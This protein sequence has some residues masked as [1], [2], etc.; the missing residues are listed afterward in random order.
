MSASLIALGVVCHRGRV[1]LIRRVHHDPPHLVWA[2]PG[3]KV[4]AGETPEA[5]I[6]REVN[7]ETNVPVTVQAHLHTR[8]I[9][10]TAVTAHYFVCAPVDAAPTPIPNNHEVAECRWVQGLEALRLFQTSVAAPVRQFLT[11]LSNE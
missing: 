9:P 8:T 11:A 2:F 7:E 1:L 4:E 10:E 6:V 5:A 3:G